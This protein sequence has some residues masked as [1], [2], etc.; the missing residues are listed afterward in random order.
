MLRRNVYLTTILFFSL[1][2]NFNSNAQG[3]NNETGGIGTVLMQ[4]NQNIALEYVLPG[5]PADKAGLQNGDTILQINGQPTRGMTLQEATKRITGPLGTKVQLLV[6]PI[7]GRRKNVD[8]TRAKIEYGAKSQSVFFGRFQALN[9][10]DT[11]VSIKKL[12]NGYVEIICEKEHWRGIGTIYRNPNHDIYYYKGV[13][14][15]ED[16]PEVKKE[17]RGVA[18]YFIVNCIL[19]NSLNLTCQWS[20]DISKG[21]PTKAILV[22]V[23]S[24]QTD[25]Q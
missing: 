15:M 25:S 4:Q 19:E 2:L 21:K 20:L 7:G 8:V 23:N 16:N 1:F 11:F 12:Q 6:R 17:V 22:K 14:Q 9:E 10:D 24:N 18:G 3:S 13:F 5:C